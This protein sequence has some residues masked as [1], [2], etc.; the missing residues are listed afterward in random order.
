MSGIFTKGAIRSLTLDN[1]AV[2]S[3]TW[4][5][6]ADRKGDVTERVL[7][8]Y[9][10]LAGGGIGLIVTGFQFVLP[11]GIA[12]AHQVGNY[13]EAQLPGLTRLSRTARAGGAKVVAQLVHTGGKADPALFP[14]EGELWGPSAVPDP[15][16]G[17]VPKEMTRQEVA[18]LVEAYAAAA[19]RAQRAGFDG[20]QLHGA[21]GYGINQFLSPF[22]N[23]RS[24]GY[25]GSTANR[26]RF[27]GEVLRVAGGGGEGI[28]PFHQAFRGRF[29]SG[30]ARAGG[31]AGDRRK[32][33]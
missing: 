23:R 5:G 32:T 31:G 25:G 17:R 12:I 22:S 6:G 18:R 24:D 33:R 9:A 7:G 2:R 4:E 20:I 13:S 11:N 29:L 28:P 3:A 1:R 21:H 14:E 30:R 26:Y 15:L 27:L 19:A 8:L 16:T 10:G